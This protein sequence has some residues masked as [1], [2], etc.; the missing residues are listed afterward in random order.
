M[1][2]PRRRDQSA[3]SSNV[4]TLHPPCSFSRHQMVHFDFPRADGRQIFSIPC[5]GESIV[6]ASPPRGSSCDP[7]RSDSG[8]V[9][10]V[11]VDKDGKYYTDYGSQGIHLRHID[12]LMLAVLKQYV[13]LSDPCRK[14]PLDDFLILISPEGNTKFYCSSCLYLPW[15]IAQCL[16]NSDYN[17]S[18]ACYAP[19]QA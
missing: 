15:P 8:P 4:S 16:L 14:L 11:F 10:L 7:A 1:P 19:I 12:R 6:T 18:S 2:I 5:C 3:V 9:I 17:I 13:F